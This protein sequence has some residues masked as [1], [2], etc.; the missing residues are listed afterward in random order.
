MSWCSFQPASSLQYSL[1]KKRARKPFGIHSYKII[2]LKVPW[3]EHLQKIGGGD[4]RVSHPAHHQVGAPHGK[5]GQYPGAISLAACRR[6]SV[7]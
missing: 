2:G 6:V 4:R 3:N 7:E 1:A 5:L